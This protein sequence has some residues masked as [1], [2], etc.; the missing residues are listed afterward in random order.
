MGLRFRKSMKIAPGVRVNFGKKSTSVSFGG[1]GA[2]YTVSS[3]GRKTASVG[4][5][6]T[7]LS[8]V[9]SVGGN[10]TRKDT[11]DKSDMKSNKET[12]QKKPKKPF[13]KK[14]WF[15]VVLVGIIFSI[16]T[17]KNADTEEG[18]TPQTD[19]EQV[20]PA[21]KLEQ[22]TTQELEKEE[23][24]SVTKQEE[25]EVS[26]EEPK[27]ETEEPKEETVD[28]SPVDNE[29]K[30]EPASVETKP[31]DNK[32][33]ETNPVKEN[34]VETEPV[35]TQPAP[36]TP[37]PD[38]KEEPVSKTYV[39]NTST[40]RFH[41]PGCSSVKDIKDYNK[42]TFTGSRDDLIAQGYKSCGRCHP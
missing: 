38:Q 29:K 13:F 7:G 20:D 10:K 40:M 4:I 39:L 26:S 34:P 35:V 2:R 23:S 5:P 16:A 36:V 22:E 28:E 3:S 17:G 6:G 18:T 1:K 32:P 41:N 25:S 8:Y 37:K 42:E 24:D 31:V 27:E 30:E 15:W 21:S 33:V 19:I 14:W 12:K 11:S 9:E